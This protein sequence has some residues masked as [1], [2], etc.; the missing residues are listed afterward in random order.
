MRNPRTL[1]VIGGGA[2][3]EADLPI[4]KQL[5]DIVAS[6]LN[7]KVEQGS[8]REETGDFDIVD[9]LQQRTQTR[10][11]I[12]TYLEAAWLAMESF[13][14]IQSIV[15]SMYIGTIRTSSSAES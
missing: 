11:G 10:E 14:Q 1:F 3:G 12:D 15:S 7:F 9:V 2:S 6:K 13:F 8:L 4:G 5:I